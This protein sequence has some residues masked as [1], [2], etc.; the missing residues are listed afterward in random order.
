MIPK[1][2]FEKENEVRFVFYQHARERAVPR[3]FRAST[4]TSFGIEQE[5]P[6]SLRIG[7]PDTD[8]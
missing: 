1:I 6:L 5:P 3:W 7:E 2:P 8:V 4:L